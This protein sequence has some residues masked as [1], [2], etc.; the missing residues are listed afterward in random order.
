MIN[1]LAGCGKHANG[2]QHNLALAFYYFLSIMTASKT[3]AWRR[4]CVEPVYVLSRKTGIHHRLL[5]LLHRNL[6][7]GSLSSTEIC[8]PANNVIAKAL[9]D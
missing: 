4:V 1:G 6:F 9:F 2:F 3:D 7:W 8:Q 5:Y